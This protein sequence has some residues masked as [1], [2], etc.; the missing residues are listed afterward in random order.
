MRVTEVIFSLPCHDIRSG[1]AELTGTPIDLDSAGVADFVEVLADPERDMPVVLLA[2]FPY[3]VS[4]PVIPSD[5]ASGLEQTAP[6]YLL[7]SQDKE[8]MARYRH[9]FS[10]DSRNV[11]H[12]FRC[13]AGC[14]RLYLP[15]VDL[16][17]RSDSRRHRRFSSDV[18]TDS[19]AWSTCSREAV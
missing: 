13:P 5:L 19:A 16:G 18:L 4:Y 14:A 9:H 1:K 3:S 2:S 17:K 12:N 15:Q 7:C 8:V 10:D 11:T 6:V